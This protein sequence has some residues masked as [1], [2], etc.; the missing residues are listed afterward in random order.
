MTS[1]TAKIKND[2]S[3]ISIEQL[4]QDTCGISKWEKIRN[5]SVSMHTFF[6]QDKT[7]DIAL[8]RRFSN[9]N[10]LEKYFLKD[11]NGKILAKMDLKTYKDC[12]YIISI[13]VFSRRFYEQILLLI[14]Q[15]AVERSMYNTT[16][17]EVNINIPKSLFKNRKLKKFII[18]NSFIQINSQSNY[19]KQ[20]FG[21]AFRLKILNS[22]LWLNKIKYFQLLA[23]NK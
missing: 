8:Y 14:L 13:E 7:I 9:K 17:K 16:Q 11:T 3:V 19:E 21:E 10:Y 2:K 15:A 6:F 1:T 18:E 12:V 22:D 23:M 5:F 4:F 20:L